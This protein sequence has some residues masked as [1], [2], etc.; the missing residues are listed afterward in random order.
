[1]DDDPEM[2]RHQMQ[3]TRSSLTDKI[4]RLEQTVTDKVQ[5]TTAAVTNTVESVKGAVQDAHAIPQ[6]LLRSIDILSDE[7]SRADLR[8]AG[9]KND[10]SELRSEYRRVRI[11][12]FQPARS[13]LPRA[14]G[15]APST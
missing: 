2:I 11:R 15:P 8:I 14:I 5:S 3:E 1:M 7:V 13:S 6:I 4:E 9:L 10:L 12:L